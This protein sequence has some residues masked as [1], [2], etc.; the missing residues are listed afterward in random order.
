MK[1]SIEEAKE[2]LRRGRAYERSMAIEGIHLTADEVAL[3][4]EIERKRMGYEEG[5]RHAEDWLRRKGA[6]PDPA[7]NAAE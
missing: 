7:A 4:D 5:I 2:A 1:L 3:I 6:I